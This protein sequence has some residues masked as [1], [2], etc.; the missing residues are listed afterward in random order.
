MEELSSTH[1]DSAAVRNNESQA[2]R[3]WWEEGHT[4]GFSKEYPGQEAGGNEVNNE[5]NWNF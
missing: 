5:D 1:E 4:V 2:M 3:S